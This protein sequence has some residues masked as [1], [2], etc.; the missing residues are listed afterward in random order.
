MDH[1]ASLCIQLRHTLPQHTHMRTTTHTKGHTHKHPPTHTNTHTQTP[2]PTQHQDN[3]TKRVLREFSHLHYQLTEVAGVQVTLFEHGIH[4]GTPDAVFPNNWFS[5]HQ[6]GEG[7]EMGSSLVLYP[8]K[9]PNRQVCIVGV[10]G[11]EGG[12]GGA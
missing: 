6:A 10:G 9:C 7:D 4:H 1:V 2:T 12:G 5:T 11:G 8:M 3:V